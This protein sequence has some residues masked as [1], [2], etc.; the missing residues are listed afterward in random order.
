MELLIIGMGLV[1]FCGIVVI[2]QLCCDNESDN[3]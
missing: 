3:L 1:L 2:V